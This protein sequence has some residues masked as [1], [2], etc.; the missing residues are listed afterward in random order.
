MSPEFAATYIDAQLTNASSL[1][2]HGE[3]PQTVKKI[4]LVSFSMLG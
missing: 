2:A 1:L 3:D 4:L